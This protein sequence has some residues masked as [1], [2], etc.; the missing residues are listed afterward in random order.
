M[1]TFGCCTIPTEFSIQPA[2]FANWAEANGFDSVWFG[3][4]THIPVK[5]ESAYIAGGDLPDYYAHF[6]DPFV[7]LTAAACATTTLKVATSV[8][9]VPE[10]HPIALAK[11]VSCIDR[12][13]N[14][15][16]ILG[17]GAGW[18]AEELANHGVA[19]EDR[20]KVTRERILAMREIWTKEE[21][22]YH[23]QFVN[24][25]PI[26]CWPKPLQEGGPPVLMGAASKWSPA[27][28]AEYC[29]GWLA[30]DLGDDLGEAMVNLREEVKKAGRPFDKFDLSVICEYHRH[31]HEWTEQ[32]IPEL[33]E[34]GF[35]RMVLLINPATPDVQ[36]PILERCAALT[37]NFR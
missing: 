7:A 35:T 24:F 34:I 16:F 26:W 11:T 2:E 25:D 32:R 1:I 8:C 31:G 13:S 10:H 29:D 4:H 19:R 6:W 18:N 36:W 30:P 9:L 17:I 37:R 21:A 14:G 12:V 3:E 20:W 27:R 23:G 5:R 22:E 15:R 33:I 28:I